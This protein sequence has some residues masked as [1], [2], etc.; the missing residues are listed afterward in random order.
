MMEKSFVLAAVM[1]ANSTLLK[2]YDEITISDLEVSQA[3]WERAVRIAEK[4]VRFRPEAIR[5]LESSRRALFEV[6][7]MKRAK[8]GKPVKQWKPNV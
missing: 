6:K 2:P 3:A 8:E 1:K 4:E 7:N 5:V